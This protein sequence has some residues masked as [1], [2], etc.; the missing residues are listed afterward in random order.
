MSMQPGGKAVFLDKMFCPEIAS[1]K[2]SQ[3]CISCSIQIEAF[4]TQHAQVFRLVG[5]GEWSAIV[6]ESR[7]I[8]RPGVEAHHLRFLRIHG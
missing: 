4:V 3:R 1:R 6:V 5:V 8:I 7:Q 2:G